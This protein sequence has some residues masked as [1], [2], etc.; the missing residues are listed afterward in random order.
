MDRLLYSG[1][2][3]FWPWLTTGMV[4]R[5]WIPVHRKE[6]VEP[7]LDR[8]EKMLREAQRERLAQVLPAVQR[9]YAMRRELAAVWARSTATG[10]QLVAQ[11]QDWCRRAEASG[12]RPLVEFSARLRS[13]A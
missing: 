9:V 6:S 8:D 3:R 1:F 11:L 12:I 2:F 5:E 13:Y 4:T 7:W 10:E